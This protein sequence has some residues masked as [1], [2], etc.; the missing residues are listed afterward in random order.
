VPRP[1]TAER[2]PRREGGAQDGSGERHVKVMVTG[3]QAR[4][5]LTRAALATGDLAVIAAV[6]RVHPPWRCPAARR[7]RGA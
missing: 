5:P 4:C 7:E 2:R 6:R 3:R 1:D